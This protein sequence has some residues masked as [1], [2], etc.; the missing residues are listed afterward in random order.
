[1]KDAIKVWAETVHA[2]AGLSVEEAEKCLH[3]L[4][5]WGY[6]AVTDDGSIAVT[7]PAGGAVG[8]AQPSEQQHA[9]IVPGLSGGRMLH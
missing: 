8:S 3:D 9:A 4:V 2:K 1:M 7:N 5:E 6:V